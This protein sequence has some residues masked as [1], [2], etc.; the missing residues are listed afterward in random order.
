MNL[1]YKWVNIHSDRE[2]HRHVIA[3]AVMPAGGRIWRKQ[4]WSI[5]AAVQG[6][7]TKESR[8]LSETYGVS[9]ECGCDTEVEAL[10]RYAELQMST[11]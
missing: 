11:L 9:S 5:P 3:C 4:V 1:L 2:G 6:E 7:A 10:A 8:L